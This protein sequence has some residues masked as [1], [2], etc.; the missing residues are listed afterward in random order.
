MAEAMDEPAVEIKT[1]DFVAR[2]AATA[3]ELADITPYAGGAFGEDASE[4][5]DVGETENIGTSALRQIQNHDIS[6]ISFNPISYDPIN[7]NPHV[8]RTFPGDIKVSLEGQLLQKFL[9]SEGFAGA[10]IAVFNNWLTHNILNNIYSKIVE[11]PI[12]E[13]RND[14]QGTV[15]TFENLQ[16]LSPNYAS[17]GK[18]IPLTPQMAR[19]HGLTYG[20][21]LYVDEV[22]RKRSC[23]TSEVIERKDQVYIGLVPIAL[24]SAFCVLRG[25]KREE[26]AMLGEDPDDPFGYF[27]VSG[28]EKSILC[29]ELIVVNRIILF[30]YKNIPVCRMTSNTPLGTALIQITVDR[31]TQSK[32]RIQ[33]TTLKRKSLKEKINKDKEKAEAAKGKKPG[34]GDEV[35]EAETKKKKK[36][37]YRSFNVLRIFR[38][39]SQYK[40]YED[41]EMLISQFLE[42]TKV[43][44]CLNCLIDSK[45]DFVIL[46]DDY[47][48]I[49]CKIAADKKEAS[50]VSNEQVNEA[51]QELYDKDLFSHLNEVP[52]V[53]DETEIQR[54]E[55]IVESK[56]NLL[57]IMIARMLEFLAGVRPYDNRDSWSTKRLN[58]AGTLCEQLLRGAWKE[59]VNGA[60]K[61]VNETKSATLS[62]I[63]GKISPSSITESFRDSFISQNW[64]V[65]RAR[66]AQI[67][68]NVSQTLVRDNVIAT[69]AHVATIDVGISRTDRQPGIRLVQNSQY[70]FVDPVSSSEGET[71]GIVKATSLSD[72]VSLD[73]QDYKY[74][75]LALSL[76]NKE[77]GVALFNKELQAVVSVVY[78]GEAL[79]PGFTYREQFLRKLKRLVTPTQ[80]LAP[81]IPQPFEYD[82][83]YG[84]GV[85]NIRTTFPL[86]EFLTL[87]S[88]WLTLVRPI[89][90]T[91][92]LVFNGKFLGWCHGSPIEKQIRELKRSGRLPPDT[93]IIFVNKDWLYVDMGPGRP[94]RPLCIVN[95]ESQISSTVD[96]EL[97][98]AY[99]DYVVA[100]NVTR[101]LSETYN[102][103]VIHDQ[104]LV[105]SR[106]NEMKEAEKELWETGIMLNTVQ[107]DPYSTPEDVEF[108]RKLDRAAAKRIKTAV[109]KMEA[110]QADRELSN[111][112]INQL[113]A[114]IKEARRAENEARKRL[115]EIRAKYPVLILDLKNKRNAPISEMLTSSCME[116][117]AP[118]EQEYI[119]L[120]ATV[121]D[122]DDYNIAITEAKIK[123]AAATE[124]LIKVQNDIT[125]GKKFWRQATAAEIAA[126]AQGGGSVEGGVEGGEGGMVGGEVKV[127]M[128]D[129]GEGMV[130]VS[131]EDKLREVQDQ[132]STVT[133]EA[134]RVYN[135]WMYTH[136]ELD[137]QAILGVA[138]SI[139]PFI[140]HN[141]APRSTYQCNMGK[142]A[143]GIYHSNH[144]SR[145]DGKIKLLAYPSR[146]MCDMEMHV[147]FGLNTKPQG[148]MAIVAFC[149]NTNY[150]QEDAFI[151]NRASL[152]S[153][154]FRMFKYLTYKAIID[155]GQSNGFTEALERPENT[156][157]YAHIRNNGLPA[158]GSPLEQG[159][160]V[161]GKT[162]RLANGEI[163]NDSVVLKISEQGVVDK[164]SVI[165][166]NHKT[167][168]FVK[169]R[170]MRVPME[171]DKFAPRNAQKGTV[172]LIANRYDMIQ[173]VKS[174]ISPDIYANPSQL[175]SRMTVSYTLEL[176]GSKAAA[177]SGQRVNAS[178]FRPV[179]VNGFRNTLKGEGLPENE[180]QILRDYGYTEWGEEKCISPLTG[181]EIEVEFFMGPV[182]WQEL[183]QQVVDKGQ[184]R[185]QGRVK[186]L[187]RQPP[188]GR[189]NNGGLRMGE[190]E[191][192]VLISHGASACLLE[193]LMKTS[194]LYPTVQCV[195]CGEFAVNNRNY[196]PNINNNQYVCPIHKDK[197]EYARLDVPFGYKLLRQLLGAL[198]FNLR[199]DLCTTEEYKQRLINPTPMIQNFDRIKVLN[200]EHN[201]IYEAQVE[202]DMMAVDGEN[203][204]DPYDGD[205]DI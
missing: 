10:H 68:S 131:A 177:I 8:I 168:V 104:D 34:E 85:I 42:P 43:K 140:G 200:N 65:K 77:T 21:S 39:Y 189:I 184:V 17:G 53:E 187:T 23:T 1:M 74:I 197:G 3:N 101:A 165:S 62:T 124:K 129:R 24:G 116:Y 63:H 106:T 90:Y 107:N 142:Q 169:I 54:K 153:G 146:P 72:R 181:K 99:H 29:Q 172:G 185:S 14:S 174:G 152:Q 40:T 56:M 145:F 55:R 20:I 117:V 138:S 115:D 156:P 7:N 179:D 161:I 205:R 170:I 88:G 59:A 84:L 171:G 41:I 166:D 139:I 67:K 4:M 6:P 35:D 122:I 75:P 203:D 160:C 30:N 89:E 61:S 119:K 158:I 46:P 92:K 69:F 95:E 12:E 125:D 136:C 111:A 57:A 164:I 98:R 113:R 155:N 2:V 32:L 76:K 204:D 31:R 71:C 44:V 97:S 151:M 192:D 19:E 80:T 202:E 38:L 135:S 33:S 93:G 178:P 188:K 132:V 162:Q 176:L 163:R 58:L 199:P 70:G 180:K 123:V 190:M 47:N 13:G 159:D 126:E 167:T 154:L 18:I 196:N 109:E 73:R 87:V 64:G 130:E 120:A 96:N 114:E 51:V 198:G 83:D 66:G 36:N 143:L 194:D 94:I 27:I 147:I 102:D 148:E 81:A 5:H 191:R 105:T 28:V 78:N 25:L 48:V 91:N 173:G 26:L 16:I 60:Q 137:P 11:F 128:N 22:Q 133:H 182:Y 134:S 195:K 175:P 201:G 86:P 141:Q 183:K 127:I 186:S 37:K 15:T 100:R 112:R 157:R 49:R 193:R 50:R 108:Y 149:C 82:C 121:N 79:S 110:I 103:E 45:T 118:W 150:A 144:M 9:K 52:S